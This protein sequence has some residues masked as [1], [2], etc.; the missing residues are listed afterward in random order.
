MWTA[1]KF[2]QI[3]CGLSQGAVSSS[4]LVNITINDLPEHREMV[5]G[6]K[7]ALYADDLVTWTSSPTNIMCN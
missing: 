5:K 1:P 2:K 6:I 7:T 4:T 3:K